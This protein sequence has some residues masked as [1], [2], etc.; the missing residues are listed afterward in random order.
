DSVRDYRRRI[1]GRKHF[2]K[3]FHPILGVCSVEGMHRHGLHVNSDWVG[4]P[5]PSSHGPAA[6]E[7][8]DHEGEGNARDNEEL[9]AHGNLDWEAAARSRARAEEDVLNQYSVR[10]HFGSTRRIVKASSRSFIPHLR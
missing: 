10:C 6:R 1:L 7:E 3:I 4:I 9:L 2:D 8:A 5:L